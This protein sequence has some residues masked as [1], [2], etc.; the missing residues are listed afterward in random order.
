MTVSPTAEL[1]PDLDELVDALWRLKRPDVALL[2]AKLLER[3]CDPNKAFYVNAQRA[4]P[5]AL[6]LLDAAKHMTSM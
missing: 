4:E 2:A 3:C 6:A 1:P 5:V